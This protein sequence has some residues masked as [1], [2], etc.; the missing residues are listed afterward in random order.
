MRNCDGQGY[1][2][3]VRE[4][5]FNILPILPS[6]QYIFPRRT[7]EWWQR[8]SVVPA[9]GFLSQC[10]GEVVDKEAGGPKWSE[11]GLRWKNNQN[12]SRVA[13][14]LDSMPIGGS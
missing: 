14:R 10:S 7:L 12:T 1:L 13:T 3:P 5:R 8:Q 2:Q 6:K 4:A 9:I 11:S